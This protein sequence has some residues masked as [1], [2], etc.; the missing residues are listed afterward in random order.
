MATSNKANK[1]SVQSK[2]RQDE[3]IALRITG[4]SYSKISEQI[5]ISKTQAYN[6]VTAGLEEISKNVT[7][8]AEALRT[9][10]VARMDEM[11]AALWP[12]IV[13]GGDNGPNSM[14]V[15][16]VLK[17]MERRTKLLGLDLQAD[18]DD[19][20]SPPMSFTFITKEAVDEI[21]TTNA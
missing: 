2:A 20:E 17:I 4:L 5:G 14:N 15:D 10:E 19:A 13:D 9:L 7:D 3:A 8:K 6:L 21:S 12:T 16:K 18:N 1:D 11:L